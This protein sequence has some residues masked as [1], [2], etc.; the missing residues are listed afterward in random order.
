MIK[1]T[2]DPERRVLKQHEPPTGSNGSRNFKNACLMM[3]HQQLVKNEIIV[4]TE[5]L[6]HHCSQLE[7]MLSEYRAVLKHKKDQKEEGN[8]RKEMQRDSK[9]FVE[10]QKGTGL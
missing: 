7:N 3:L 4:S 9:R 10:E 5:M 8:K 1:G 2:F 6:S